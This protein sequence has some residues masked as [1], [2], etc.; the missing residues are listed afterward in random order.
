MARRKAKPDTANRW[1]NR[2]IGEGEEAP[3]QLLANPLNF[4]IHSTHQGKALTGALDTLGWVQRVIV[5]QR[6]GHMLDGHLRV[7]LALQQ[8]E[9]TIPVLYVDL[10]EDEERI[11]LA[12]LDPI[13]AMAGTDDAQ[14]AALLEGVDVEDADLATFLAELK[15]DESTSGGRTSE[16]TDPVTVPGE[17]ILL[18]HHRLLCGDPAQE[19]DRQAAQGRNGSGSILDLIGL[20]LLPLL[21]TKPGPQLCIVESDPLTCDAIVKAWESATGRPAK[22]KAPG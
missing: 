18:G 7:K 6:T 5:N 10:T 20:C 1:R 16:T 15:P 8:G 4:R 21:D 13:A 22:R 11:A 19:E 17:L 12:T 2:I 14:L 9:G 3:D